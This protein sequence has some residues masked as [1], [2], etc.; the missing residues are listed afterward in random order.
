MHSS[1]SEFQEYHSLSISRSVSAPPL[2]RKARRTHCSSFVGLQLALKKLGHPPQSP[3]GFNLCHRVV[4]HGI[5]TGAVGGPK[6]L[7]QTETETRVWE[8]SGVLRYRRA[9]LQGARPTLPIPGAAC[10]VPREGFWSLVRVF[11]VDGTTE[12]GR[13]KNKTVCAWPQIC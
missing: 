7:N 10:C 3:C 1:S 2:C 5:L 8:A 9:L 13:R 6:N 4:C 12:K 11:D